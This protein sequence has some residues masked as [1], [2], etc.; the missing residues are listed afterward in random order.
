MVRAIDLSRATMAASCLQSIAVD[1]NTAT[2]RQF[3]YVADAGLGTVIVYDVGC[4]RSFK[5][6]VPVG[7]CGRRD[8]MYMALVKAHV[9]DVAAGGGVAHHQRLYVTYLSSCEMMYVPV[10]AVDESTV[11][12]ATV[13]IGRK[14]CK[15]I[16]L[17]T[18]HGSVVYFRTGDTSG[19][20]SWN[21]NKPLREKNFR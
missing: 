5:V 9:M 6:H 8:V 18:D 1:R 12:L 19:I 3:V 13:T 15:M 16:V 21:V 20:R 2:G 14:P 10:H 4:D 11:S 17:G 7:P